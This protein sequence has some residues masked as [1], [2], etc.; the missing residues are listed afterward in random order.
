MVPLI[1]A[2]VIFFIIV[3]ILS[4][5]K[6]LKL[7]CVTMVNGGVKTGKTTL[8]VSLAL[9]QYKKN[10]RKYK[11]R[12]F[13]NYFR[14]KRRKLEKPLLYSNIPLTVEYCPLTN[15]LIRRQTR[16]RYGSV[17]I[18]SESSLVADSQAI[19]SP[20]LNEEMMLFIKLFGHE[21]KGGAMF[22]DTQAINDNHYAIKRCLDKY[23]YIHSLIK[24]VPFLLIYKIREMTYSEDNQSSVNVFNEDIESSMK[25]LIKF[26]TVWKKFDSYCYSCFTDDCPVESKILRKNKK[27]D[28]KARKI[29]TFK[30]YYTLDNKFI[31][32]GEKN[33][34]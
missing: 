6:R 26:K 32:K 24:W 3:L 34:N 13:F 12:K 25:L 2:F 31:E 8:V 1:I 7:N 23:L 27:R 29:I 21:T 11:V 19:R 14:F 22:I 5:T 30:N 10:L 4:K 33:E 28:L 18:L 20:I 16:F 17:V 15:D 9:K